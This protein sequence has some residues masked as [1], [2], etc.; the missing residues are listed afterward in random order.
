[1]YC[2]RCGKANPADAQFCAKCGHS[3]T[4]VASADSPYAAALDLLN[5]GKTDDAITLLKETLADRVAADDSQS[6]ARLAYL[7]AVAHLRRE[8][9]AEARTALETSLAADPHNAVAHAYYG[10]TLMEKA[11]IEGARAELQEAIR[12]EPRNAVVHIKM[13]EYSYRLGFYPDAARNLETARKL[14]MPNPE[15]AA[16]AA[17]LSEQARTKSKNIVVRNVNLPS[18]DG[19]RRGL[20][21][22]RRHPLP[23]ED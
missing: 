13:A 14:P 9:M 11:D 1:M 23:V 16:Y 6:R 15:T 4:P 21:N 17:H 8:E 5:T 2:T 22:L 20:A 10:I 3:I 19:L 18:F 12:L 7:L